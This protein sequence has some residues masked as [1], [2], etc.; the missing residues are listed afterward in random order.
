MILYSRSLNGKINVWKI[1]PENNNIVIETGYIGHKLI[2]SIRKSLSSSITKEIDARIKKQQR[3]GYKSLKELGI[4]SF[5]E[6]YIDKADGLFN[7]NKLYDILN[8]T[9]PKT[10]LD[11]NFQLKPNK[12]VKFRDHQPIYPCFGQPKLNGLRGTIRK[13]SI[14]EG[15]G[16]FKSNIET[17]TIKTMGGLEYIMPNIT[18][19]I[20]SLN[21]E[22]IELA[23]DGEL[24]IPGKKLNEINAA[25]P[26]RLDSGTIT[27][28]SRPDLTNKVK[29][30]C[31]DLAI[32]EVD[33]AQ[34][35]KLINL[36]L[37]T[38]IFNVIP[39]I[40]RIIHNKEEAIAFANECVVQ[41][42]EGAVFRDMGAE[43]KFG[44]RTKDLVKLKFFD[45][46]E[47]LVIDV[48]SKDREPETG[49]FVCQNNINDETF[50]V[51]PMG[52]YFKRKE[53]LD[54]KDNYIG[55]LVTVKF[56]ERSGIKQVPFHA[57]AID[58]RDK[59]D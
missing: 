31:F 29:F 24:Y 28:V 57:N 12:A 44:S 50:T 38:P 33:Q 48:V 52:D 21:Y 45:D 26:K 9:L 3:K 22:D 59:G 41:G 20:S 56:Y 25:V 27:N 13:E 49:M 6:E 2:K 58:F 34:R 30:Y 39:V 11:L 1:Y 43:Y 40:T 17:F 55:R 5:S 4:I 14:T 19:S 36:F 42:F 54:N 18:E 51:N 53:Y 15:I 37:S 46:A 35:L 23:L 16:M 32:E 7:I 47:F 10:N 8:T